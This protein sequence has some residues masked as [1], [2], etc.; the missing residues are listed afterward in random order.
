VA[1]FAVV[2]DVSLELRRQVF[3]ALRATP[4]TDFGIAGAIDRI[5]LQPP[6]EELPAETVASLYL[7]HVDLDPYRRNQP[8][9]PDREQ[10]RDFRNPP[11]PLQLRYLFTPVHDTEEVNQLLLG[12]VLQHFDD[13]RTFDTLSDV[14]VGDGYGGADPVLR[15][16]PDPLPLEQLSQLWNAFSAPYRVAL[17][18]LVDIVAIDSGLAPRRRERVAEVLTGIGRST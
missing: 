13:F 15:I 17:A 12:R 10:T 4:D 7:Y 1:T 2:H 18:F 9:L 8:P 14:P 16:T 6:G 11:L 5:T 3:S